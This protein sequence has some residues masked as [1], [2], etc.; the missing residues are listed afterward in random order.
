ML[1]IK[2]TINNLLNAFFSNSSLFPDNFFYLLQLHS[3]IGSLNTK[4]SF[5]FLSVIV[6][7]LALVRSIQ[8]ESIVHIEVVVDGAYEEHVEHEVEGVEAGVDS[9]QD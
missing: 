1:P 2:K 9:E 4:P 3:V 5:L 8:R 7:K 6:L